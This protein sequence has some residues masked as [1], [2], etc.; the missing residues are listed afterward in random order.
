MSNVMDREYD[1]DPKDRITM[2]HPDGGT[3]TTT[4]EGFDLCWKYKG[5]KIDESV[6]V[7]HEPQP[8][9]FAPITQEER[10]AVE[11]PQK[12]SAKPEAKKDGD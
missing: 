5:W 6:P 11:N 4:R 3:T 12:S 1:P 10:D 2:T 9:D 8:E 7:V